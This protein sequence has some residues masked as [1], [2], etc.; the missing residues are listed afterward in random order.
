MKNDYQYETMKKF[1]EKQELQEPQI[2][3]IMKLAQ[4]WPENIEIEYLEEWHTKILYILFQFSYFPLF[5]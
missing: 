4:E 5:N 1:L 2:D 3:K